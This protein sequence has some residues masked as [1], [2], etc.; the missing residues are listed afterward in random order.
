[1]AK[2]SCIGMCPRMY[3]LDLQASYVFWTTGVTT[4]TKCL[5]LWGCFEAC[6]RGSKTNLM[7]G[8][9]V[10]LI[11]PKAESITNYGVQGNGSLS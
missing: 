9:W 5:G 3:F 10:F 11:V 1:M 6:T 7:K 8:R 2:I 4:V